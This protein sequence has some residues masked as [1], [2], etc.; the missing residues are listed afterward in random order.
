MILYFKLSLLASRLVA[1]TRK[2][3]VQMPRLESKKFRRIESLKVVQSIIIS[4]LARFA[5]NYFE[6]FDSKK[7]S[8]PNLGAKLDQRGDIIIRP[9]DQSINKINRKQNK[10]NK[11]CERHKYNEQ[12]TKITQKQ[13][14]VQ[15]ALNRDFHIIKSKRNKF[16]CNSLKVNSITIR[17]N[18]NLVFEQNLRKEIFKHTIYLKI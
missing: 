10:K 2:C 12:Q 8:R 16:I 11:K 9:D 15:F 18:L 3:H 17:D 1:L 13:I 6:R 7:S 5:L 14:S 4:S